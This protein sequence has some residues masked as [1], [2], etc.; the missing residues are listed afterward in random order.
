MLNFS[1]WYL[2]ALM[3]PEVMWLAQHFQFERGALI[4]A[5]AVHL[6][7]VVLFSF[8]HIAAMEARQ[9]V[10]RRLRG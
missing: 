10:A 9:L 7:A 3:A 4:R 1:W 2:W 6:P 5:V 8:A